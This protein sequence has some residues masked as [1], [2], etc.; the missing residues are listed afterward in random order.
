M[1]AVL[2]CTLGDLLLDV[3]VRLAAPLVPGDDTYASTR[4]VAGGQA[5]NVA[6]WAAELGAQARFVGKRGGDEAAQLAAAA[7]TGRGVDVRGPLVA[8][9]GGVV[10][11]LV[12]ADGERTMASDRGVSADLTADELDGSWF[13]GCDHL[14]LSGYSL[15]RAPIDDAALHAARL[16]RA[17]GATI[18]ID[19]SSWSAIEDYG[20]ARFRRHLE[21]IAPDV[22]LATEREREAIGGDLPSPRWA[23]KL[24]SRGCL[25]ADGE[26]RLA[27]PARSATVVD[28]TGA[29]DAFAAGFLLG[30]SLDEAG[31]R[32]LDAA[33]RCVGTV[34]AMP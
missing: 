4:T 7:L 34:G 22:L 15:L 14:H 10:V 18:S 11:S 31:R 16:A 30:G 1:P 9:R 29:G 13:A 32:G 5:A 26:E 28:T 23:L 27:L 8:G 2:L 20:A 25:L 12:D 19:L 17:A 6:A 24:G 3:I 33:A 21:E